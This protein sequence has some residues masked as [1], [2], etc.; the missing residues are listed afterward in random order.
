MSGEERMM[1]FGNALGAH[2]AE[3]FVARKAKL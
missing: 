2:A 1:I 3:A